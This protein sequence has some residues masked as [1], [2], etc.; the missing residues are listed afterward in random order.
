[1]FIALFEDEEN[2]SCAKCIITNLSPDRNIRKIKGSFEWKLILDACSSYFW[3][4]LKF[5]KI[6]N[7]RQNYKEKTAYT[8]SSHTPSES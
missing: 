1:M 7:L 4:E 3:H 8:A 2:D 6:K 5:H